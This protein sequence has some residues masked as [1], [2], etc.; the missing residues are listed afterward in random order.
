MDGHSL[1]HWHGRNKDACQAGKPY[2]QDGR[3]QAEQLPCRAGTGLQPGPLPAQDF[4]AVLRLTLVDEVAWGVG[5]KIAAQ[6]HEGG[7]HTV[8]DLAFYG[9][10]DG[11]QRWSVVLERTVRELQGMPCIELDAMGAP[12]KEIACTRS[13]GHPV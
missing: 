8:L 12:R 13:F 11:A 1:R 5:R 4:E 6:L 9:C 3:A 2:R 7:V 10:G